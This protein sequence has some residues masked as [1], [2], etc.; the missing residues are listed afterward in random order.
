MSLIAEVQEVK[1]AHQAWLLARPNVIGLGVGYKVSGNQ[2]TGELC[3]V[4]LVRRKLPPVSLHEADFIPREVGGVRTD[5]FEVGDLR[6]LTVYTERH[7]P[8][9]GGVSLGH[10]QITAGTLGCVVRDRKTGARMILSNNHVL[11]NR[12]DGKPGDPILQPGPADGG[13]PQRDTIALLERFETIR[14][15]QQPAACSVAR[16]YACIGNRL[17][18]L[19]GS[20][21]QVQVF[22]A[23]PG[24]TN[25]ID[26]ALARPILDSDVLDENLEIG[27]INGQTEAALSLEVCKSGRTTAFTKGTISVLDATVTVN[28]GEERTATFDHQIVSTPMSEGGDSGSLLVAS[29]TKQAVGLLFAGSSQATL[30]NPI[31]AVLKVL[32]I[33]LPGSGAKSISDQRSASEKA[34]AVKDA[35]T[36]FLMSKPNV[37]GVG[38][39]LHKVAGQRTGQV[40]LVVMVSRKVA[41][42]MLRPDDVIPD[43]ID[44][45][46]VDVRELG[47]MSAL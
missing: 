15:N 31:Q 5:V 24:A 29:Q 37:V 21:H 9:P 20:H 11:A 32:K 1:S 23:F 40:G 14:Y 41:V 25:L 16:A 36:G 35:Y 34:Q 42:D 7:R 30:F 19:A 28:Y 26:A 46:P 22:Q 2:S 27:A 45:V 18:R 12:N 4:V 33:D 10:Y 13:S 6:P 17:A 44:G 47:E 43:Q 38:I 39:G 8:A 3:V